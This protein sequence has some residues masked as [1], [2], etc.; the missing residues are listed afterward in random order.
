MNLGRKENLEIQDPEAHLGH[1]AQPLDLDND[2]EQ[3]EFQE[4]M[5]RRCVCVAY[6]A[7]GCR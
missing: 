7:R 1:Q 4:E 5:D 6:C 2:K 3:Q